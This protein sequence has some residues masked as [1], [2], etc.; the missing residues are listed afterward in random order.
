MK[1]NYQL[2]TDEIIKKISQEEKVPK[3]LLHS[4]C[5]P[6][7][8]YVIS[9]LSSYFQITVFYYN[10]NIYPKEEYQKRKKEQMRFIKEFQT[11]YP[12]DYLDCDYEPNEFFDT[13]KGLEKE[14]EGKERCTKC[15][16]L[17]MKE[18]AKQAS[19]YQY[20]YFTTTLSVSPYKNADK[21]NKIGSLLEK[22]YHIPFLYADFKKRNGYKQSISLS[23][24]Y[25]LYRQNYCGCIFSK[26]AS[27]EK[28]ISK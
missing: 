11:K 22:E 17:R 14:K 16:Y 3:L 20:D 25:Q 10:P 4:C 27:L 24:E 2:K 1:E 5:A 18:T 12:V 13:V 8:S 21:I 15:Y 6:C 23:K 7:S 19:F 26:Q 9:Y 28:K